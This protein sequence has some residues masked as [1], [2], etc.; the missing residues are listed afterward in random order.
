VYG[1][2]MSG[3]QNILSIVAQTLQKREP[4]QVFSDQTRM[5]TYVEDVALALT[6]LI[7]KQSTGIFHISGS[8]V[9]T[10]Y[11]MACA[12]AKHLKLDE[13]LIAEVTSAT[14]LQPAV[15]PPVTGFDLTKA[16]TELF[17]KPTSFAEGLKKT[18]EIGGFEKV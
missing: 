14:F 5:P 12:V 2:P 1:K 6:S 17:Y 4:Y 15:R 9:L 11:Q 7:N 8:D 13:K 16:K 18:F 10:P 3:R